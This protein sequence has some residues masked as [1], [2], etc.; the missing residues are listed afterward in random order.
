MNLGA[1]SPDGVVA[2]TSATPDPLVEEP[3]RPKV[4][5]LPRSRVFITVV[6][7]LILASLNLPLP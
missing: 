4:G 6:P 3:V 1:L 7:F 2:P 5:E